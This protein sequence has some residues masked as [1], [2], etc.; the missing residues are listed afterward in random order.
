MLKN[1]LRIAFRNFFKHKVFSVINVFGLSVGMAVAILIG[2][3]I[4]DEI[5]FNHYHKNHA[6]LGEIASIETFN[7]VTNTE[8]YSSVLRPG[9]V[10]PG[11]L[12]CRAAHQGN[13]GEKSIGS[14]GD[15]SLETTFLRIYHAGG[16]FLPDRLTNCLVLS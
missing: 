10:W 15:Q 5:T 13:R 7:G 8:E 6:R 12:Y 4:R 11:F 9:I 2:L 1:Y 3:W 16:G 14:F